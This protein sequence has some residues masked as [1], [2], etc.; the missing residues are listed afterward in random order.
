MFFFFKQKTAYE[1][2]RSLVG[3]EMCIRDSLWTSRRDHS[4]QQQ[5]QMESTKGFEE[6]TFQPRIHDQVPLPAAAHEPGKSMSVLAP[7]SNTFLQ[8][9]HEAR[10]RKIEGERRK[11]GKP[12][13]Q[14]PACGYT[15]PIPFRLGKERATG[16]PQQEHQWATYK[17][18]ANTTN[19]TFFTQPNA[20]TPIDFVLGNH[21]HIASKL[22]SSTY[23]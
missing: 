14:R 23:V 17:T 11:N 12:T 9:M 2:L 22:T 5:R 7:G 13:T 3:S 10:A 21:E 15:T 20:T 18:Q 16:T 6:C 4:L 1:M 19:E 8:R